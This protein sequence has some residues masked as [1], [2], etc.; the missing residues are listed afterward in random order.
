MLNNSC[1]LLITVVEEENRMAVWVDNGFKC[2]GCSPSWSRGWLGAT[3]RYPPSRGRII[4]ILLVWEKIQ[5]QNSIYGFTEYISLSHHRATEKFKL[6]T[7]CTPCALPPC[8]DTEYSHLSRKF[9]CDPSKS[10]SPYT[11]HK[12]NDFFS[13][14]HFL[15]LF[16]KNILFCVAQI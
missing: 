10:I 3:A 8:Q 15:A 14:T 6:G 12:A 5:I 1:N 11:N 7:I 13:K 16:I 2:V 4:H 9:P